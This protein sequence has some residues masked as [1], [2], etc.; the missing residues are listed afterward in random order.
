MVDETDRKK[1][2]VFELE[3]KNKD[4]N[5]VDALERNVYTECL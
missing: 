4:N 3:K 1:R 2:S 5:N